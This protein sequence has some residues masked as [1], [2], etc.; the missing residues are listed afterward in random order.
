VFFSFSVIHELYGI[1]NE[2]AFE[3]FLEAGD[4]DGEMWF[5]QTIG[6]ITDFSFHFFLSSLY[7]SFVLL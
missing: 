3:F 6:I 1:F 7:V 2:A 4:M 5:L